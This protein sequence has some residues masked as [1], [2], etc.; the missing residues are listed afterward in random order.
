MIQ[1]TSCQHHA[2]VACLQ[3]Q[4]QAG[5]P[6]K[7]ISFRYLQCGECRAPLAHDTLALHLTPH[8]RLQQE[9]EALC[10]QQAQV[11]ELLPD[12]ARKLDT[13]PVETKAQCMAALSC[14]LCSECA[15]PFC[16]GKVD[17]AQDDE[18]DVS[19]L[20]CPACVFGHDPRPPPH[21][22]T[23]PPS[24]GLKSAAIT[25]SETTNWRG[26]C[27]THGYKFAI[28]KCDSCCSV[29]T[30]DCRSNHYCTRCHDRASSA[31]DFKC[32]G[33]QDCPLGISHPP[34]KPGVHG[35]V[36]DGFVIGCSMCFLGMADFEL[37]TDAS[38]RGAVDNWKDR[39]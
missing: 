5:W 19:A 31:K 4:L 38:A 13:E 32:P 17:C 21:S 26:K 23:S 16:G 8:Q 1:L 3:Q 11:D 20:K 27:Q 37:A 24:A 39:F 9:V 7:Q 10:L 34:N 18:L 6:G 29:A 30:W 2:H 22:S 15:E 28:Y 14:Y 12:F 25:T 36:D 33:G 35:T